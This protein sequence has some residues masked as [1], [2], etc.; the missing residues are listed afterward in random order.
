MRR[1]SLRCFPAAGEQL[2]CRHIDACDTVLVIPCGSM[3]PN[4]DRDPL[5]YAMPARAHAPGATQIAAVV[6]YI[7]SPRGRKVT[8]VNT[9][10]VKALQPQNR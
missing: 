1:V 8:G 9:E 6:D 7:R 5:P 4:T 2:R 10:R 3:A